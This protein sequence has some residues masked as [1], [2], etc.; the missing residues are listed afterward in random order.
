MY[1]TLLT[2]KYL[3]SKVLPLFA[4]AAVYLCTALVLFVWS[5]MGGFLT[6]L[7]DSGRAHV[8]DVM[9]EWPGAGFGYY[10]E[11]IADLEARPEIE[12]ATPTIESPA[13]IQYPDK[14]NLMVVLLG[15]DPDSYD[16][17]T[18]FR[19]YLWWKPIES[20]ERKDRLAKD[21]RIFTPGPVLRGWIPDAAAKAQ[22]HALEL[23]NQDVA[24]AEMREIARA[25]EQIGAEST[26]LAGKVGAG[27]EAA[28]RRRIEE[29]V[30]RW[31]QL[32]SDALDRVA[33]LRM[34][35]AVPTERVRAASDGAPPLLIDTMLDLDLALGR[36]GRQPVREEHFTQAL[37]RG[38]ELSAIDPVSGTEIPAIVLGT[39]NSTY[40]QRRREGYYDPMQL[41]SR[42]TAQGDFG[43][44]AVPVADYSV[45]VNLLPTESGSSKLDVVART[46]RVVNEFKTGIYEIDNKIALVR[47]D[48]LQRFLRM[49][50]TDIVDPR[51]GEQVVGADGQVTVVPPTVIGTSPARV[52]TVIVRGAKGVELEAVRDAAKRVYGEFAAKHAQAVPD[53]KFIKIL[54]WRDK[55]ATLVAA[56][57]KEIVMVVM[58]MT[59]ISLVVSLLILAIF[60]TIVREKTRD[61]GILRAI[62]AS[63]AGVMGIWMSYAFILGLIGACLG[64]VTAYIA[65]RNINPIHDWLGEVLGITVWSPEIYYINKIPNVVEPWRAGVVLSA[66]VFFALVGA[67]IPAVRAARMDPVKALRFE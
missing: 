41:V 33:A 10:E 17:V 1:H 34:S 25:M 18:E 7:L 43:T 38:R 31:A 55:K 3:T 64:V 66:G 30:R 16:K 46:F 48:Y 57:E 2:R 22:R 44:V 14:R 67:L 52:T 6:T 39:E 61:I 27:G 50:Q 24:P 12:A 54:T 32:L 36:L 15:V 29:S 63:R 60:W 8:G 65:V 26:E 37:A 4:A 62:G 20:P 40:N 56:V 51:A 42:R 53:P 5:I 58:I 47:L 59:V 11:L 35:N 19:K 9:I 28:G 21:I 45:G 23:A 13:V 49:D